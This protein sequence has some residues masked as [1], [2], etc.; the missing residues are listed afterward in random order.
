MS[1][2]HEGNQGNIS[3]MFNFILILGAG[4]GISLTETVFSGYL[5]TTGHGALAKAGLPVEVLAT[6]FQ[7]MFILAAVASFIGMGL[8]FLARINPQPV[9]EKLLNKIRIQ[10]MN[11]K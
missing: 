10:I 8:C 4:I 3:G 9:T 2:S 7:K 6:G 5:P 1:F 11:E